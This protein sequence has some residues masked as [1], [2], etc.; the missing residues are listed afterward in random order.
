MK[1]IDVRPLCL[2]A[3][4]KL[5]QRIAG[6]TFT[7]KQATLVEIQT[8]AGLVGV[9]ECLTRFAPEAI[10]AIIGSLKSTLI[11]SDPT[12]IEALWIKMYSL[13]RDRGHSK[14]FMVEA[15]SGIDVALWDI[16]GKELKVPVYKLLG[17]RLRDKIESYATAIMLG[18]EEEMREQALKFLEEGFKAM[19][20]KIGQGLMEDMKS[21]RI[22]KDTVGDDVKLMVDANCAYS[23]PTAI[24]LGRFLERE[25]IYWFEEPIPPENLEG[26]VEISRA[27]DI[28]VAAG[29]SEFTRY[30][31]RD[32][33]TKRAVDIIQ[34]DV[35]RAGGFS[36]V[37]RI[38]AMASAYDLAY[39]PHTG[40]SSA[41]CL[42]ATLHLAASAPEF[43]IFEY[44]RLPNPLREELLKEPVDKF[45]NGYLEIPKG[46]GLGVEL[47]ERAIR[48]YSIG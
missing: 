42:A 15:I 46:S 21:V 34:P 37:K 3:T 29:E 41:V 23:V 40:V 31:F 8:D 18:G 19:K 47:E 38:V 45:E 5:P 11:G 7:S 22:V 26:Y 33:I 44:E 14:G 32:L 10:R 36:E 48:K 12:D 39:A 30:G 24:K 6:H 35:C 20:L 9:G 2:V 27:L 16:L 13:M 28:P 4:L 43:L 25:E 1:I 17:G